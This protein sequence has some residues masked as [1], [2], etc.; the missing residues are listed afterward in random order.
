MSWYTRTFSLLMKGNGRSELFV[1]SMKKNDELE[2]F[3]CSKKV[4]V[5]NR[6]FLA[7]YEK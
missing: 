6:N 4:M 1:L 5:V 3:C 7:T 2:Q